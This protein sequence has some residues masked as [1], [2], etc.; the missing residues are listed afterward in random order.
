MKKILYIGNKLKNETSNTTSI[1]ILGPLLELEGY[2]VFYSSSKRSKIW[3]MLDM[4]WSVL[5]Y[6]RR[7]DLVLIDTYST[8]NFYYALMVSQ[9]C[10][11][12]KLDYIPILRGGNLPIRLKNNPKLSK[13]IFK[14]AS[15]NVSPSM[16][17][18]HE[19]ESYGY[20]NII[21]IPNTIEIRKYPFTIKNYETPRLLWVRSFSE[22]YNPKLA[23]HVFNRIKKSYPDAA[24][25]MVGP[26]TDGT[27]KDVKQLALEF[28][29]EVKFTGKLTKKDW[30]AIS[31]N[32]NIF[33]NT[34]NFDNMPVSVIE[35]MALGL[36][37][38]STN[39]GGLP[40]LIAHQKDGI[41]V[42]PKNE[43]LFQLALKKLIENPNVS[44]E[45][46]SNAR[47]KVERFDWEVIKHQWI[48]LLG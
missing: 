18:K 48:K 1:S 8:Q 15:N 38:V 40:F 47:H 21:H 16:Y 6:N 20:S 27:L 33:I 24:L 34:T 42:P 7:I 43:D 45:I 36:P 23:I 28:N 29:L 30:I 14:N 26:D 17:L 39:V 11:I 5:H 2:T 32:Y 13:L 10:R 9:L 4:F 19:F 22:I 46:A 12:L 35:A 44:M 37:V 3:R 25:C 41:L 31:H